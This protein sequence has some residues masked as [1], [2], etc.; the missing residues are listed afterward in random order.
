LSGDM[1]RLFSCGCQTQFW[2]AVLSRS[3][4]SGR[5]QL[6]D[7]YCRVSWR[8]C[9]VTY[10]DCFSCGCPIHFFLVPLFLAMRSCWNVIAV[11]HLI[12]GDERGWRGLSGDFPRRKGCQTQYCPAVLSRSFFS[13]RAQL[14]DCY[15]R[16][17]CNSSGRA[18]DV[19]WR[20]YWVT[21]RECFSCG[22]PIH[23]S[24]YSV[25]FRRVWPCAAAGMLSPCAI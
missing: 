7:C 16:V 9:W 11:C 1:S 5:A 15:C 13:G 14:L 6:L 18:S 20:G 19:G 10:R 2:L 25:S 8:S 12:Q 22:C 17:S 4:F 21:C 3:F 23:L 24:R